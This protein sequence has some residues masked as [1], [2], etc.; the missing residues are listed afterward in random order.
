[1]WNYSI[2]H[3][4]SECEQSHFLYHG[5]LYIH[6]DYKHEIIHE[7]SEIRDKV[8]KNKRVHFKDFKSD[9]TKWK[10]WK[11]WISYTLDLIKNKKA[12]FYFFGIDKNNLWNFWDNE[13]AFEQNIYERF[14]E[15]WLNWS[16]WWFWT[17]PSHGESLKIT[18]I[19]YELW[20]YN[21]WREKRVKNSFFKNYY[22]AKVNLDNSPL[23]LHW[24]H[25]QSW[26]NN[27][28]WLQLV[29]LLLWSCRVAYYK[30]KKQAN[31]DC[32]ES[33]KWIIEKYINSPFN[34]NSSI[35]KKFAIS[36]FP[37]KNNLSKQDFLNNTLTSDRWDF[38]TD[39]KTSWQIEKEKKWKEQQSLF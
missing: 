8:W 22:N 5:Y 4:E 11:Q 28:I 26:D 29:D 27:S 30:N 25:I 37:T 24:C 17:N 21:E 10:L 34:H 14:F 20:D 16:L 18:N 1:M 39:R 6:N 15:I 7:L 35:Y 12:L 23:W 2:Y 38:Y 32:A 31:L 9:S 33:M 13:R 3:D 36:F 19:Y